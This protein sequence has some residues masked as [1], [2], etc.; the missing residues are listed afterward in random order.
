MT[1]GWT[2]LV[3]GCALAGGLAFVPGMMPSTSSSPSSRV[4]REQGH[5]DAADAGSS[6]QN[7]QGLFGGIALG[8]LLSVA[9]ASP[10]LAEEEAAKPKD[11]LGL[12]CSSR[13]RWLHRYFSAGAHG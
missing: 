5:F 4:S 3:G 7:L 13:F 6:F 2:A 12:D 1:R 8:L 10:V 11:F 9:A